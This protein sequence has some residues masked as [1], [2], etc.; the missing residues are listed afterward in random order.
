[1]ITK[2]ISQ[3]KV[4]KKKKKKWRG[5]PAETVVAYQRLGLLEVR[6]KAV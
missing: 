4:D 1:M 5:D 3:R 2:N 6:A